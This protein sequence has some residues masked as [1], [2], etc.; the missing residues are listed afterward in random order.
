MSISYN[1]PLKG[2]P[3]DGWLV[4]PFAELK[5]DYSSLNQT[6]Y[7]TAWGA[8]IGQEAG[9]VLGGYAGGPEGLAVVNTAYSLHG[10]L[11]IRATYHLTYPIHMNHVC[12]SV[13]EVLWATSAS[14]PARPG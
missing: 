8:N 10:I 7:L 4:A 12:S 9:P 14:I 6:A 5:T 13:P 3:S 2:R 11:V 1:A